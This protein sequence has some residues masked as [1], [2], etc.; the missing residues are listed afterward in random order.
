MFTFH[1]CLTTQIQ[2]FIE[3]RCLSGTDYKSQSLLLTYFDKFLVKHSIVEPRMTRQI[4]DQYQESLANLASKTQAGRFC[5]ARQLCKQ[6]AITDPLSYVPEPLKTTPSSVYK[7]YIYTQ[8][9]IEAFLKAAASLSPLDS[10]R[11]HTY[12]TL[13]G[14]LYCT[15]IRISEA[16]SL[17]LEDVYLADQRLYVEEGKFQKSR[18]IPLE[19][20]ACSA[21]EQYI[22]KRRDFCSGPSSAPL[23]VNLRQRRLGYS[24]ITASFHCLRERCGIVR[25][26]HFRPRIHSFRHTF[27]VHRLLAWYKEGK[28]LNACLPALAT[29]MGHVDIRSTQIYLQ[30]TTELLEQVNHRFHNY[31][32]DNVKPHMENNHE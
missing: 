19:Q 20:S 14:L 24:S 29:Y 15:G 8:D 2:K 9:E 31:Y 16:I 23:F 21:I 10:L 22:H 25:N 5:V 13:F 28:D 4:I 17:N 18:W 3:L 12:R 6:L 11:P 30:P 1:S 32:L 7:P 26:N 27:A